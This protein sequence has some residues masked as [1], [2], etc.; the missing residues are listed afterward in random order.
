MKLADGHIRVVVDFN[1]QFLL[2]RN[3]LGGVLDS[4][5]PLVMM[6]LTMP[7]W[8]QARKKK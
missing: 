8:P 1:G 5:L 3:Y 2:G 6:K 7:L 4:A